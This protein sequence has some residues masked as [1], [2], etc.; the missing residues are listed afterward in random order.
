[1]ERP[2]G[3]RGSSD[4]FLLVQGTFGSDETRL[5]ENKTERTLI[6]GLPALEFFDEPCAFW[7]SATQHF[8]N[9]WWFPIVGGRPVS[10]S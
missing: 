10:E 3:N 8:L 6:L 2:K 5:A 4:L 1:M 9:S 7:P